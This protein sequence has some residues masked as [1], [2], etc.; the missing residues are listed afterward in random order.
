MLAQLKTHGF[1]IIVLFPNERERACLYYCGALMMLR[2]TS[3]SR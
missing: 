3:S 2:A 1:D